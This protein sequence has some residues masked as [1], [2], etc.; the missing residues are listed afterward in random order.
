MALNHLACTKI[1]EIQRNETTQNVMQSEIASYQICFR[2]SDTL[3]H[4]PEPDE[5]HISERG[6]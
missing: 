3:A 4:L 2:S 5:S 1:S 6:K